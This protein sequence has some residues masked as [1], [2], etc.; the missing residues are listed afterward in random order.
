MK[1]FFVLY[2]APV[3]AMEQ[4]SKATLEEMK[5]GMEP[6]FEWKDKIGDALVDMGKPLASPQKVTKSG[7]SKS[8]STICGYSILH[9]NSLDEAVGM[10]KDHPHLS[11]VDGAEIEVLE[12]MPMPGM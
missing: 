10:I 3:G 6:W 5:K 12:E 1:K 8:N 9:A 11:W 7:S 4:M 2:R